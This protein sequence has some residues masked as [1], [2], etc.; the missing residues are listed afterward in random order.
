LIDAITDYTAALKI[1]P[2]HLDSLYNR[3]GELCG[4]GNFNAAIED[5]S[6]YIEFSPKCHEGYLNRAVC[7][8]GKLG[9]EELSEEEI[10][11]TLNDLSRSLE[12]LPTFEAYHMRGLLFSNAGMYSNAISDFRAAYKISPN[13]ELLESIEQMLTEIE[14]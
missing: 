7:F 8:V 13:E 12:I 4:M 1:N 6:K 11:Q 3:S 9:S 2:E 14:L 5:I 10:G